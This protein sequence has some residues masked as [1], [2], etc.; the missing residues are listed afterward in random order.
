MLTRSFLLTWYISMMSRIEQSSIEIRKHFN[1][2]HVK[3]DNTLVT[4]V[5]L[6]SHHILTD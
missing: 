2:I 5:D 4:D 3:D 1:T 6:K